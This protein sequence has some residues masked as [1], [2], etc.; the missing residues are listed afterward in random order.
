MSTCYV[1]I[2]FLKN[3]NFKVSSFYSSSRNVAIEKKKDTCLI[4]YIQDRLCYDCNTRAIKDEFLF[5][6]ATKYNNFHYIG[7]SIN[8]HQSSYRNS[9]LYTDKPILYRTKKVILLQFES[10]KSFFN[11]NYKKN[12]GTYICL[13]K[14]LQQI[15]ILHG[16]VHKGLWLFL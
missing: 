14:N 11:K 15:R 8:V 13:W 5:Y 2:F 7:L 16:S 6:L 9:A 12:P 10:L 3:S 4:Q 1:V